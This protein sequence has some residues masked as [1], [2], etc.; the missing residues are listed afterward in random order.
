MK[1]FF[2]S[3]IY[4]LS[5]FLIILF[6]ILNLAGLTKDV[7]NFFYLISEPIQKTLWQTGK[8]TSDF[9]TGIFRAESLKK[10]VEN[11]SFRN[12]EL[13][14]QIVTLK[15]L[16]KENETLREALGI[17]L[18]KEFQLKLS[19]VISKD[20]SQDSILI[21]KGLKDGLKK[22]FPVITSQK[23]LLGRID[24]VY[25]NFSKVKLIS[26]KESSFDIKI[27]EKEIYGVAKGKGSL[28]LY[29]DFIPK[30]Q[31]ISQ[32]ELIVTTTL[33]GIF[34]PGLLVGVIKEIKKSDIEPFQKAEILP[35]FDL[36]KL[37]NLF[38]ITNF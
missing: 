9:L 16:K 35:S 7:K 14:S 17:G 32:G 38:I 4:L 30:D 28:R 27:F 26:N 18:E 10:E 25:Q 12:Q 37:N 8:R 13:L 21:N 34:P 23:V 15:E 22:D 5:I 6:L 36:K 19:Q 11:L 24:E 33:G 2:R 3:K 29:L 20:I 31:E 1:P